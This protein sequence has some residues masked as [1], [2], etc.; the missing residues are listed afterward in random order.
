MLVSDIQK[1]RAE[2]VAKPEVSVAGRGTR[3]L[4]RLNGRLSNPA[5]LKRQSKF[6]LPHQKGSLNMLDALG[7]TDDC[8][9]GPIP[10]GSYTVAAPLVVAGDTTGANDTVTSLP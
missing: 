4:E 1:A 10:G 6:R 3:L 5:L 2:E 8:P 9:G 7:G